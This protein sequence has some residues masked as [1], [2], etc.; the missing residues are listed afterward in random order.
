[1]WIKTYNSVKNVPLLLS[2]FAF[3][4]LSPTSVCAS[5]TTPTE[6]LLT[7]AEN[8]EPAVFSVTVP[9]SLPLHVDGYGVVT[10]A[11]NVDIIN[12]S[13]GSVRVVDLSVV[14]TGVYSITS[15]DDD[16]DSKY[17]NTYEMAL[18]INGSKTQSD[19]NLGFN[20]AGFPAIQS[21]SAQ[22]IGYT[23]KITG[24]SEK[25]D[26]THIADVYVTIDW[27]DTI[28]VKY[29]PRGGIFPD[30]S[31]YNSLI[32]TENG[33]L[34]GGSVQIPTKPNCEF[35]G[36]YTDESFTTE[37]IDGIPTHSTTVY[38]RWK[39]PYTVTYSLQSL[40]NSYIYE[41]QDTEY[42][43]GLE[44]ETVWPEVKTYDKYDSPAQQSL[45]IS[46]NGDSVLD[47]RYARTSYWLDVNFIIDGKETGGPGDGDAWPSE[48]TQNFVYVYVD[49]QLVGGGRDYCHTHPV[50]SYY[51]VELNLPENYYYVGTYEEGYDTWND[52]TLLYRHPASGYLTENV[53]IRLIINTV[54]SDKSCYY[55]AFD[56][57]GGEGEMTPMTMVFDDTFT[58]SEQL[59]WCSF[60]RDGYWFNGWSFS[61]TAT[62]PDFRDCQT[63]TG[64]SNTNGE[65]VTLYAVWMPYG[66]Y[67]MAPNE[68]LESADELEIPD[69]N[70]EAEQEEAEQD[71]VIDEEIKEPDDEE[72]EPPEES[73]VSND[74]DESQDELGD[75][76]DPIDTD[77]VVNNSDQEPE[78]E[79]IVNP[80]IP[81]ETDEPIVDNEIVEDLDNPEVNIP[82]NSEDE[83]ADVSE[84]DDTNSDNEDIIIEVVYYCGLEEHSHEEDCDNDTSCTIV[85]HK[86]N[87]SCLIETILPDEP[88][89][90]PDEPPIQEN[91]EIAEEIV[92][93][94]T[95]PPLVEEDT[96]T[97]EEVVQPPVIEEPVVEQPLPP[98]DEEE[99]IP[100]ESS[101]DAS[102]TPPEPETEILSC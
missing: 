33:K 42:L 78:S 73:D 84:T 45:V 44:G 55:I 30:G 9:T 86:H 98:E 41:I 62:S 21:G 14:P 56:N 13:N 38:A 31:T 10:T 79:T 90:Q 63:V 101:D 23:A 67:T 32:Y 37:V 72:S 89:I 26:N 1:M 39:V 64:L 102:D 28:E 53:G 34:V 49:G 68:D 75:N 71:E 5:E 81:S 76:E 27:N 43:M 57:N 47:Y 59:D 18:N 50:D 19:G 96:E 48:L 70:E 6:E 4:T 54:K 11:P 20:A 100:T 95:E 65:V 3:L 69:V 16:F 82:E 97:N 61:P 15:Y 29:D 12:N 92:E 51:S 35:A 46:S 77:D 87:E 25:L 88:P 85:E 24:V 83:S 80:E 91:P 8:I 17:I 36:W 94:D 22:T 2:L 93:E 40:D 58:E 7:M 74:S 66:F 99:Y 60:T 52:G